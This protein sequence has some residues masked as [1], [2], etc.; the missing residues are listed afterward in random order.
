MGG[1]SLK[2]MAVQQLLGA[3]LIFGEHCL[4][5]E[6]KTACGADLMSDVL[7][8]TKHNTLLCTG[9]TNLQVIRTADMTDLSGIV[10]DVTSLVEIQPQAIVILKACHHF[11]QTFGIG[12]AG[13]GDRAL[14]VHLRGH[15]V[16]ILLQL[17]VGDGFSLG[18]IL[19]GF[20]GL[21]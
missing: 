12:I 3:T 21:A 13:W 9:L 19:A 17:F 16:K 18:Q 10:L 11:G 2:L 7:A 1:L 8:F 4:D 6:V 5:R 15:L 20:Q 14:T